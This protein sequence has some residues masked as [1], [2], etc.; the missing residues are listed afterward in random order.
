MTQIV[1]ISG[2][3]VLGV[4]SRYGADV[5]AAG[6]G[7]PPQWGT[8]LVNVVGSF[9]AGWIT[10]V[11]ALE[12]NL[13]LRRAILIGFMGGFT[14]FSSYSVQSIRLTEG[15]LTVPALAYILLSPLAGWLAAWAGLGLGRASY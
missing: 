2:L 15:G 8:F 13:E 1:W 9:L 3:G 11:P 12:S 5:L 10:T 4:L 14:T 6:R 7:I